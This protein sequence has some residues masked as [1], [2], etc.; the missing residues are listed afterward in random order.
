MQFLNAKNGIS[1]VFWAAIFEL[2]SAV[3]AGIAFSMIITV[4]EGES[5]ATNIFF[6]ILVAGAAV[7]GILGFIFN[8]VGLYKAGKDSSYIKDAFTFSIV[9]LAASVVGGVLAATGFEPL[10]I[11]AQVIT[12]FVD[13]L[14]IVIVMYVCFGTSNLLYKRNEDE[15]AE[16]GSTTA[17][18]FAIA[19]AIGAFLTLICTLSVY[20]GLLDTINFASVITLIMAIVLVVLDIVAYVKFLVFLGKAKNRLAD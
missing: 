5:I 16:S 14:E 4:A 13:I 3:A 1:K 12:L 7:L 20:S 2:I 19:F 17:W 6:V 18:I 9:G 11:I 8:L 10:V 15:V